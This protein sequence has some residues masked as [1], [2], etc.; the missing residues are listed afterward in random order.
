MKC[1]AVI[2]DIDGTLVDSNDA[3]A[4]AWVEAFAEFD[5]AADYTHVRRSVGMGGDKL[6]PLVS[7]LE[8]DSAVGQK[9][10][11]RRSAIFKEKYLPTLH[12]T[13]GARALLERFR[14]DGFTL[15]VATSAKKEELDPLLECAGVRDLIERR[16]SSDDA[17]RSKP[18]PDIVTAALREARVRP[19][20]AIMLGDTPYDVA[21]AKHAGIDIVGVECGGWTR[22]ALAG[23]IGVYRDPAEIL[24]RYEE[25]PFAM[26]RA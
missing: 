1:S 14:A 6:M 12:A 24:A 11:K 21:A 3:H 16:T 4:H 10:A 25:S 15:A 7:G 17:E 26:R 20:E 5:I 19:G 23:A 22:E 13:P 18:D 8:E 2:L 9:I